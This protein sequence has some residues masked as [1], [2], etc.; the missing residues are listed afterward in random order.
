MLDGLLLALA[1]TA[2]PAAQSPVSPEGPPIVIK[3][4]RKEK[5]V[6]RREPPPTGS[7]LGSRRICRTEFEW[8][9][10]QEAAQRAL[11]QQD[12][13]QRAMYAHEQNKKNG[14]ADQVKP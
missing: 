13:H 12:Q 3:G 6:C 10:S 11:D 14:L 1:A 7:R 2:Q 8:R 9:M 4:E 5:K